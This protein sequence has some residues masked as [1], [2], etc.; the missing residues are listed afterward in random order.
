M[1]IGMKVH[2]GKALL[3]VGKVTV[4]FGLPLLDS[5]A[6]PS[7]S[8]PGQLVELTCSF[9]ACIDQVSD[10]IGEWLLLYLFFNCASSLDSLI[11]I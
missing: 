9:V 10:L 2:S 4:H 6:Q 8:D 11:R 7:V 3:A 5:S 1:N